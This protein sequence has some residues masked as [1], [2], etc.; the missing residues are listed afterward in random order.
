MDGAIPA[1]LHCIARVARRSRAHARLQAT[2]GVTGSLPV[3]TRPGAL[4]A[5]LHPLKPRQGTLPCLGY[6]IHSDANADNANT[7]YYETATQFAE[8]V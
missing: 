4:L 6:T 7:T 2:Y 8:L 3:A 1:A 5:A